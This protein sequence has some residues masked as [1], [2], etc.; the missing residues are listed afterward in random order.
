M[1]QGT[2]QRIRYIIKHGSEETK[3]K[4]DQGKSTINKEY[5]KTRKDQKRAE[6]VSQMN[7]LE[8]N[9]KKTKQIIA[10]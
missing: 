2:Y 10:N 4:L 1:S 8:C 7:S 3:T 6:F 5:N 9:D